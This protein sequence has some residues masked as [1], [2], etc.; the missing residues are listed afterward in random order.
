[1]SDISPDNKRQ[2][3][4]MRFQGLL[5]VFFGIMYLAISGAMYFMVS[6]GRLENGIFDLGKNTSYAVM[7]I[8]VL[9]G[10]FRIGRAVKIFKSFK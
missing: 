8:F 9:Y 10:A 5:G 2:Q 7:V 3:T 4:M 1:M 6:T